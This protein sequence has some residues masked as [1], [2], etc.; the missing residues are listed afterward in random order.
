MSHLVNGKPL[1]SW[2]AA[3]L[4]VPAT[5]ERGKKGADVRRCQEWLTLHGVP[6]FVDGD[7]GPATARA[8]ET[9]QDADASLSVTG[10]VDAATFHALT[11]PLRR[12]LS[13]PDL[14]G[15]ATREDAVAAFALLHLSAH[16]LE[17]GGQNRGPWV[18]LYTRGNQGR[19]WAW[20]AGFVSFLM[21]QAC[22]ALD[23]PMPI[24]GSVSCD[25][26]AM[27]GRAAG[28]FVDEREKRGPHLARG[29]IFLRRRTS[30]DWTHCGILMD[31]EELT[32]RSI[33]GNTNDDGHRDGYEVCERINAY[34]KRDFV[35]LTA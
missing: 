24:A 19:D 30:T 6:T 32:F 20:C 26:L 12:V 35:R 2:I 33:E 16:P 17:V 7:F 11:E 15:V 29:T 5:L 4:K 34:A 27:Q 3:E 18:R 14:S 28:L 25:S 10:T 1:A 9:F 21:A 8:V 31:P 13:A 23:E 22:E